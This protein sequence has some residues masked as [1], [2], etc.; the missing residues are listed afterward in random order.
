M[1]A[2]GRPRKDPVAEDTR[3]ARCDYK[4]MLK[5]ER[6]QAHSCF[7]RE[8]SDVLLLAEELV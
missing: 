4:L 3:R 7:S 6:Y 1:L 8:L 5:L 2:A